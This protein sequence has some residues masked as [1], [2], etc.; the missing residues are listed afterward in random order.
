MIAH[1]ANAPVP[2]SEERPAEAHPAA[3]RKAA[4]LLIEWLEVQAA[5][6]GDGPDNQTIV[7]PAD[8]NAAD[9]N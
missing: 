3:S 2:P 8:D 4:L 5:R 6:D 1:S 7:A 9:M